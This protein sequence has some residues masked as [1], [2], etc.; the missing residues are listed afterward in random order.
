MMRFDLCDE[1]EAVNFIFL[2]NFSVVPFRLSIGVLLLF[3]FDYE[4]L[5]LS[6]FV[7]VEIKVLRRWDLVNGTLRKGLRLGMIRL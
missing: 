7:C 2:T 5:T 4:T 6:F 1:T 3:L